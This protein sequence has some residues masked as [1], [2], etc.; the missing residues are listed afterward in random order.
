MMRNK[1]RIK[2]GADADI[3]IFDPKTVIDRATYDDPLQPSIGMKHV[4]VNGTFLVKEGEMQRG[5][6]PGRPIR[7]PRRA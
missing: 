5:S 4:L 1:G 6:L 3:V 2:E 7:A